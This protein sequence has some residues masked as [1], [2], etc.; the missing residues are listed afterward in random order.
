MPWPCGLRSELVTESPAIFKAEVILR[1]LCRPRGGASWGRS[2]GVS[3]EAP[4]GLGFY[5]VPE[6]PRPVGQGS[7]SGRWTERGGGGGNELREEDG[8]SHFQYCPH[9]SVGRQGT[10]SWRQDKGEKVL[11]LKP[12]PEWGGC[13]G[14]RI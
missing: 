11:M 13:F 10:W 1:A 14:G 8:I 5:S 7:E 2:T 6:S 3:A 9:F 4:P 12:R